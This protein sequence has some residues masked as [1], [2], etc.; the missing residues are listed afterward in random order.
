MK[1]IEIFKVVLLY[2]ILIAIII[3]MPKYQ[4]MSIKLDNGYIQLR[5]N[6]FTG[7]LRQIYIKD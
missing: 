2:L 6:L 1:E 3:L 7:E 4:F 5:G